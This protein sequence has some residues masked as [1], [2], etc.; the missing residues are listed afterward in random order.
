MALLCLAP[1]AQAVEPIEGTWFFNEGQVLV[2]VVSPGVYR[3]TVV[4]ATTFA[5]CQHRVGERMWE[6]SGTAANY[7][8]GHNWF[9][10]ACALI[11]ARG[12]STWEILPTDPPNTRVRFCTISPTEGGEPRCSELQ[13]AKPPAPEVQKEV[14]GPRQVDLQTGAGGKSF[15]IQ[16]QYRMR[17][18][19]TSPCRA[20]AQIRTRNGR[21]LYAG[22]LKGDGKV[23]L[24]TR[25]G[26]ELPLAKKSRFYI[27]V[28]KAQLLK[29][30]FHTEQG[31]WRV[32]ET[33]MRVW[34]KL[35]SGR[36]VMT[37]RDGRIRVS[38]ARIKSGA[39]PGLRGI[40]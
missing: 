38:I 24:G 19:C 26:L 34:I 28:S 6:V 36:E 1:A 8:G 33:R 13:R 20:R 29:T 35:P 30:P 22:A 27:S 7:T 11:P 32:A 40:L 2:E 31:R 3:G 39:L 17:V 12:A 9:D 25:R 37:V 5:T 15:R 10:G 21:R 4:V 23:V 18:S 16:V 14:T